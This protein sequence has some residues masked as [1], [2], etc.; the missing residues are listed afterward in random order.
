[1][2]TGTGKKTSLKDLI[3]KEA[4]SEAYRYD[5]KKHHVIDRNELFLAT[6]DEFE[7]INKHHEICKELY[8]L[9]H[10]NSNYPYTSL[11]YFAIGSSAHKQNVFYEGYKTIDIQK[12]TKILKW[13][14]KLSKQ[15]KDDRFKRYDVVVH[16][17]AK[18][19]DKVSTNTNIFYNVVKEFNC[20]GRRPSS[21]KTMESF[22]TELIRPMLNNIEIA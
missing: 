21:W 16:A 11:V 13:L 10:E 9:S 17:V 7:R 3:E 4:L 8:R 20:N 14:D 18:F 22:Y 12:A 2:V 6:K 19:Y 15:C 1:M 5:E